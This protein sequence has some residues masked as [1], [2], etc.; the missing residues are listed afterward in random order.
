MK[1]FIF[2]T[3]Y[4]FVYLFA[5][6]TNMSQSILSSGAVRSESEEIKLVGTIGQIFTSKVVSPNTSYHQVLGKHGTNN[7]RID[8]LCLKNFQY[9]MPTLTHLILRL[10]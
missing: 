3:F 8:D 2:L 7:L 5:Q 9:L 1:N 6:N 4:S 10:V